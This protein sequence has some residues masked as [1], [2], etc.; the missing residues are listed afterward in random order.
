MKQDCSSQ[1]EIVESLRH[2][3]DEEGNWKEEGE[4]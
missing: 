4:Q 1:A 3:K 2:I